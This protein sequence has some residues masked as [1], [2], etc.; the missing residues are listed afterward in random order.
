M[1]DNP[2]EVVYS[3]EEFCEHYDDLMRTDY[4]SRDRGE[5]DEEPSF[6]RTMFEVVKYMHARYSDDIER[7]H[8]S[9]RFMIIMN[10]LASHMGDFDRGDYA[11]YGSE[12][13][14]ALASMHLLRAVHHFYSDPDLLKRNVNPTPDEI[15]ALADGYRDLG[16]A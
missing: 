11:V 8:K 3:F 6:E 9:G 10:Y 4:M 2:G 16:I 5:S 7:I 15:M 1:A 13:V 14:G 12:R